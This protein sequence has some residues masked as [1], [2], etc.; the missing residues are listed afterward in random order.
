MPLPKSKVLVELPRYGLGN[1]FLIWA[2]AYV[3]AQQH[4]FELFARNWVHVPVG[5]FIRQ[6]KSKRWYGGYFVQKNRWVN[7]LRFLFVRYLYRIIVEPTNEVI[8]PEKV[9]YLF[10]NVPSHLDYFAQLK[11]HRSEVILAFN[12]LVSPRIHQLV[13]TLPKPFIGVHIRRGDFPAQD[14]I[15][16]NEFM[17]QI[18]ALRGILDADVPVTIF[19]DAHQTQI[20]PIL[21]MP[22]CRLSENL[23]DIADLLLLSQ[24]KILITS[25]N[26][27]F[28][29]WAAFISD[30]IIIRNQRDNLGQIRPQ[31]LNEMVYEGKFLDE[32]TM[33][34]QLIANLLEL[35][36]NLGDS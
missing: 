3:F 10:K 6:E 34:M 13:D 14:R 1:K 24:S 11:A 2:K 17:A 16:L 9:L 31:R 35:K 28:S 5:T 12:Q 36:K 20:A 30:A 18:T 4:G 33:P 15:P 27:T 23:P 26:S 29:Y 22:A 25:Y 19:T 32:G 7:A 8:E 21:A